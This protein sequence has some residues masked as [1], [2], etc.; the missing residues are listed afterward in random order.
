MTKKPNF[1]PNRIPV[2]KPSSTQT[3]YYKRVGRCQPKK[4]GAFCCRMGPLLLLNSTPP[5]TNDLYSVFGWK[6]EKV[7]DLR[8]VYQ[9][10]PC[11][12]LSNL[13]CTIQKTKPQGC[14]DF[15]HSPDHNW[16]K[17]AKKNGCTYNFVKIRKVKS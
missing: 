15:P 8:V 16:Y 7:G 1:N 17:L 11:S 6:N 10:Q 5:K 13:K 14:V 3:T 4:C 9:N 2:I 12:K